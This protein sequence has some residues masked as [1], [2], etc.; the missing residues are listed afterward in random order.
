MVDLVV[1]K[2]VVLDGALDMP[3]AYL[4]PINLLVDNSQFLLT[5]ADVFLAQVYNPAF[6]FRFYT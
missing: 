1:I 5:V 2:F 4:L 3:P 6:Y